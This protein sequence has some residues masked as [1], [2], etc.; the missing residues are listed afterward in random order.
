MK[1]I[2]ILVLSS[3]E[4]PWAPLREASQRTWD[5]IKVP[6]VETVYYYSKTTDHRPQ[7]TDPDCIYLDCPADYNMMHWRFKLALDAVW[8]K[9]WDMIFRVCASTYVD[10]E[11]L[12]KIA[13]TLPE[14]KCIVGYK[15]NGH[16]NGAGI[17]ISRDAA[18]FLRT[19]LHI[20]PGE[21]DDVQI[22]SIHGANITDLGPYKTYYKDTMAGCEQLK[23]T[24]PIPYMVRCK[25]PMPDNRHLDIQ[26]FETLFKAFAEIR[27]RDATRSSL[28]N[29]E[30]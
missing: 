5:S 26:A 10:K 21:N 7:T 8:E 9:D 22:S 28:L 11:E 18:D 14:K 4:E 23:V 15:I 27:V 29:S 25:S 17:F 6:G 2:L 30:F 20:L 3:N 13:T 12:L 1:K 16:I 19:C 24:D